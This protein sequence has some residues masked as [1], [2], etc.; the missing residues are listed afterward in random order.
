MN[1]AVPPE[2][3]EDVP[4]RLRGLEL[5][6]TAV[7]PF[8]TAVERILPAGS[9]RKEV[10]NGRWLGH[11]LHPVLTDVTIGAWTCSFLLDLLAPRRSRAASRRL[12][13]LGVLSAAPTALAGLADWSDLDRPEQRVGVVH[14][15]GNTLALVT[16]AAS[17]R[18]RRRG[19]HLR[20]KALG[21]LGATIATA[22]GY[23]GGYLVYRRGVGVSHA[24]VDELTDAGDGSGVGSREALEGRTSVVTVG[25]ARI[26]VHASD[27][28]WHAIAD[29]CSH[30]GGPLHEGRVE[31]GCVRCPWHGSRFRLADGAVVNG[32][33][34]AP[35]PA[36]EIDASGPTVRVRSRSPVR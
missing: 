29:T 21:L 23:L 33:A 7:A 8:K 10:L 5:L 27:G 15:A 1:R 12:V 34:T 30:Q 2:L 26:L 28:D 4:A 3:V 19:H 20:G 14:A 16:F 32:P 35:Q 31:D 11:P 36:F 13:A 22:A 18:A 6:D 25:R 24:L 17:W 9:A